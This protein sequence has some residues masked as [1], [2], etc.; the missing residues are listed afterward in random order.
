MIPAADFNY[1]F[2]FFHLHRMSD[3]VLGEPEDNPTPFFN[4]QYLLKH[5]HFC[6]LNLKL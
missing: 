5:T 2:V 3:S 4:Q 6:T 1:V